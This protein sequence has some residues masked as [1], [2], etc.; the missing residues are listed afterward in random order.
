MA[1]PLR[2]GLIGY[3]YVGRTMHAPL[4]ASV[5]GLSLTAVGSSRRDEVRAAWPGARVTDDYL[6]LAR[7][8]ACDLVVI[9]TPNDSHHTL[10]RAALEAGRHVVVDKPFTVTLAQADDLIA[11][12]RHRERLL[13]VFHNRRWDGDFLSLAECI[14]SGVLGDVRE[15]ISR[16]DRFDPVPRDR[17]RERPGAGAGLWFDLG[18]HLIDQALCLFG[19]P[20]TISADIATLRD[21]AAGGASPGSFAD[22]YAQVVLGYPKRRVNLHCTR[23]AAAPGPRFEAHGTLGSFYCHGLDIQEEQLKAGRAPGSAGWGE[24][25]EPVYVTDSR[26]T[27]RHASAQPREWGDYRR[28]YEGIRD[29][30]LGRGENPVPPAQARCVM[31][32][33]ECAIRSAEMGRTLE[34][35]EGVE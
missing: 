17:W 3:G 16:F 31:A 7:D 2:V 28:Y 6:A 13:S 22:D 12:A 33:L 24:D 35:D 21:R 25:P 4:I 9:A 19:R 18:P 14:G 15:L 29:A 20:A 32:V 34:F 11:L 5:P 30:V 26:Q 23:L 8:S 10:A 27:P 1:A